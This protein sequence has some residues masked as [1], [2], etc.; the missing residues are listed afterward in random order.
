MDHFSGG[1][2]KGTATVAQG[3]VFKAGSGTYYAKVTNDNVY[4]GRGP[5]KLGLR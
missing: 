5:Y 1:G 3:G 4:D 2:S